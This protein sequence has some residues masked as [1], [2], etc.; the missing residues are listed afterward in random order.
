MRIATMITGHY[1]CPPPKGVI[2]APM[3]IV[4]AVAE[5][6]TKR[7]QKVYFF[8]PEGSKLKV[9]KIFS[10]G[11]KP[12]HGKRKHQILR[13][14]KIDSAK[15]ANLWDQYL[16]SLI[17]QGALKGEYDLIHIHPVDRALPFGL[18]IKKIPVVYTLHDPIYPWRAE[19][20]RMFQ[21]KNQYFV[22]LSDAQRKPAPDLNWAGTVYNG[23]DLK[24]FPFS[25]KP[26][27]HCLFLGRLLPTKGVKEAIAACKIT[28][29]RL[30]IA[31]TPSEGDYWE[32][33]IKPHLN[34]NIQYV[35]NIPYEET[36]KYYGQAKVTL[37]PI[38]WEEPF[39][40]TFIESMA[41]GTP[42][43]AFDRGSAREIIKDG[44][45]GFVVKNVEEMI[46][47]I[48]KIGEIKREG[49][50]RWVEE[51]FTI[52]RMVNDYEKVFYQIIR[53]GN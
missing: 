5:G 23:L 49:C 52:E 8:G 50:R 2:Y 37:C 19:I 29:E 4:K 45:T 24:K 18:A 34:K 6:L 31:G 28:G 30:I 48:K 41:T 3:L 36:Y 46:K 10:G 38:Q 14:P 20:F 27:D 51:K 44:E 22:S 11:L 43:I 12:L 9:T 40:L 17:Y 7:G 53:K 47:A 26:K 13:D 16:I 1:T 33:E 25:E 21:S 42:V 32:K 15:A 39:G 35:G